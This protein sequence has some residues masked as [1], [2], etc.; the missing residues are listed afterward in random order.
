MKT[1]C[2]VLSVTS[3]GAGALYTFA[4]Q[5]SSS[6]GQELKVCSPVN[7]GCTFKTVSTSTSVANQYDNNL[8][9]MADPNAANRVYIGG[10]FTKPGQYHFLRCDGIDF[11]TGNPTA[12]TPLDRD[13]TIDGSEPHAD[14]RW[15]V[16]D[17]NGDLLESDD[18][19][20]WKRT[21]PTT[22]SGKW[23]SLSGNLRIQECNSGAY[24]F[25]SSI[26]I[27]GAQDNGVSMGFS[28]QPWLSMES[29]DGARVRIASQFSPARVY[30]SNQ[31]LGM[32]SGCTITDGSF[33]YFTLSGFPY[34]TQAE[35]D[36]TPVTNVQ[37]ICT[38][39]LPSQLPFYTQYEINQYSPTSSL[40]MIFITTTHI[41][42]VIGSNA[43]VSIANTNVI[44][45]W[46]GIVTGAQDNINVV[47]VAASNTVLHRSSALGTPL[48]VVRTYTNSYAVDVAIDPTNS[49]KAYVL[50]FIFWS[51]RT[52]DT[53]IERTSDAG[54]T[55]TLMSDDLNSVA[56]C[57][58]LQRFPNPEFVTLAVSRSTA[59]TNLIWVGGVQ[60]LF[61][62]EDTGS[63]SLSFTRVPGLPNVYISDIKIDLAHNAMVVSTM[64]RGVWLLSG[65]SNIACS[66][67][68]ATATPAASSL[69]ASESPAAASSTAAAATSSMAVAASSIAAATSSMAVAASTIA[70]AATSSMAAAASSIAAAATSSIAATSGSSVSLKFQNKKCLC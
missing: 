9:V 62:A 28:G 8:V 4:G 60:G 49:N 58:I 59:A 21:S 20:I 67:S 42:E 63:T 47:W 18:G 2:S 57:N 55:W 66:T 15:F 64:G 54:V 53:T 61:V 39:E 44:N 12:C 56:P 29:G 31:Y 36:G 1:H 14:T 69:Q 23:F 25:T 13:S 11:S 70:A 38:K 7:V 17:A 37:Q 46:G 24:D 16:I 35:A 6:T 48:S 45:S 50:S 27:C 40:S 51:D 52:F 34:S 32:Q 3:A 19:G 41:Y 33:E 5:V 22:S 43:P 65:I 30:A 26:G 68:T 10:S